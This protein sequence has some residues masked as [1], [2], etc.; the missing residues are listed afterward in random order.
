MDREHSILRNRTFWSYSDVYCCM[1][2]NI[3]IL[4]QLFFNFTQ[5]TLIVICDIKIYALKVKE[6]GLKRLKVFNIKSR[7]N[8]K[9]A[10][11]VLNLFSEENNTIK[12]LYNEILA[13][14]K[15]NLFVF[16]LLFFNTEKISAIKY[17]LNLSLQ[18]L[19]V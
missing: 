7:Y 12:Y 1:C 8:R 19:Y 16:L 4:G 6:N 14:L 18:N 17:S 11:T 15:T 2:F 13:F 9:K 3:F 10:E 5:L